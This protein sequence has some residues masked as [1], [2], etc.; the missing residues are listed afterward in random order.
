[1]N[2][3]YTVETVIVAGKG[4]TDRPRDQRRDK[5]SS[6][7]RRDLAALIGQKL[8]PGALD[9][10][11]ARLEKEFSAR[12]VTHRVLRGET[13]EHVRVEFEV[14]PARAVT[15]HQRQSSS[16]TIPS[17]AGAAPGRA[18]SPS[19]STL[20]FRPGQRRR[21]R[22]T[23]ATPEFPPATRTSAWVPTAWACDSS[24]RATTSSG[25]R[26]PWTPWRPSPK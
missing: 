4:W 26:A 23:N 25:T 7:L 10:L 18:V 22:L 16:S 12:E 1:M 5:I 6:G 15:G 24:S 9:G 20:R 14:E 13:P 11:A 19:G 17:R 3:R 2:T 8:N 21:L